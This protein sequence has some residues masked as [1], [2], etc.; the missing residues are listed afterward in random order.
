MQKQTIYCQEKF[1]VWSA[2]GQWLEILDIVGETSRDM[3]PIVVHPND[4][5]VLIRK[6]IKSI[7]SRM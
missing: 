6:S 4:I 3:L 7:W 2:D 1:S 5:P